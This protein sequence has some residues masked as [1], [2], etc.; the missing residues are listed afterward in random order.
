[1]IDIVRITEHARALLDA[2]GDKAEAEA[3]QKAAASKQA[4]QDDEAKQ[5]DEVRKAIHQLRSGHVS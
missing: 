5:W 1:M 3:A 4:G 2:H